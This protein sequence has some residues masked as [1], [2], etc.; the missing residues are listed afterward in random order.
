MKYLNLTK[1]FNPLNSKPRN[2]IEYESFTFKGGEPHIKINTKDL[3]EYRYESD[4]PDEITITHQINTYNDMGLLSIAVD[5]LKR[6]N[7]DVKLYLFLPYFPGARQDRLMVQGE[8][9]TSAVYVKQLDAMGFETITSFDLH[10]DVVGGMFAVLNTE[11]IDISNHKFVLKVLQDI[12]PQQ[13]SVLPIIISPDAGSNKKVGKLTQYL[14]QFNKLD[15]VKCDKTRDIKTGKLTG[16]IAYVDDLGKRD[17]IIVDDICDGGGTFLGLVKELK[18]KNAGNVYLVISHGIFSKGLNELAKEFNGIYLT[19]SV[20]YLKYSNAF[21]NYDE[22]K[23]KVIEL[24]K[25]I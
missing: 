3:K 16:F 14:S 8:P 4:S 22:D 19:D 24:N 12:Y 21:G 9:L 23:F 5:A 7:K 17:C 1:G 2:E 25:I 11:F 18:K 15:V 10:S 20:N 6:I 13:Y